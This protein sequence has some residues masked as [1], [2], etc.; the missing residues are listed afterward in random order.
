MAKPVTSR[1]LAALQRVARAIAE[2]RENIVDISLAAARAVV[3]GQIQ[4]TPQQELLS[5]ALSDIDRKIH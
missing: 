2:V 3:I 5:L 1:T 4:T